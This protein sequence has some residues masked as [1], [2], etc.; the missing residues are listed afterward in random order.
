MG[1]F[2][3]T[4]TNLLL[5]TYRSKSNLTSDIHT[6]SFEYI[7]ANDWFIFNKDNDFLSNYLPEKSVIF[8]NILVKVH[9]IPYIVLCEDAQNR[10]FSHVMSVHAAF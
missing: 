9:G 10:W 8:Q 1:F 3:P 4:D 6:I 2:S 5:T 7:I